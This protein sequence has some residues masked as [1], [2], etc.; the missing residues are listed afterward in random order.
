MKLIQYSLH[1]KKLKIKLGQH[2]IQQVHKVKCF[3]ENTAHKIGDFSVLIFSQ[4]LY[5]F[6]K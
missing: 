4:F 6:L 2:S 3:D 1:L 5:Y